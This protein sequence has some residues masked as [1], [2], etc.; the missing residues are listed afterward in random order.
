M[1]L[2]H[3]LLI[4]TGGTVACRDNGNGLAPALSGEQLIEFLPEL[5][6]LC[7]VV[8]ENLFSKDSTDITTDDRVKIAHLIRDTY[9]K[10]DGFVI[11]H[12]TD[13]LAYTAALLYHMLRSLD[14]P[15]I[16]TGAQKP[17]GEPGSD[18]E[19]M[20]VDGLSFIL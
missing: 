3:V 11:A 10:F 6:G 13:T 12:G 15:V 9:D 7:E 8:V 14:K 4:A 18:A 1:A 5:S 16:L 19:R 17:I 20:L 2:K